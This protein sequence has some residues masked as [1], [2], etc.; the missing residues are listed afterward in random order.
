M[1]EE[2]LANLTPPLFEPTK[3]QTLSKLIMHTFKL[4]DRPVD[5][6]EFKEYASQSG[7]DFGNRIPDDLS[8]LLW[9]GCNRTAMQPNFGWKMGTQRISGQEVQ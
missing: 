9:L 5:L 2:R 8:I 4:K 7:F 1:E 3:A 6:D